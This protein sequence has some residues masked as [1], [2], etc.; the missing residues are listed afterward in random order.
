MKKKKNSLAKVF[1]HDLLGLREIK[2]EYLF[3]N[4]FKDVPYKE[5]LPDNPF[6]FFLPNKLS[7]VKDYEVLTF[8]LPTLSHHKLRII[9]NGRKF[10]IEL[11]NHYWRRDHLEYKIQKNTRLYHNCL[12]L[13]EKG[14]L[15]ASKRTEKERANSMK[16]TLKKA[17]QAFR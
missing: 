11:Y 12:N 1:Y 6:Y 2:Y 4:N 15:L 17:D 9:K 10:Q 8:I 7:N 14:E 13:W 3:E 5:I 16:E